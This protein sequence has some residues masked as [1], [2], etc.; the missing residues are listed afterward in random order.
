MNNFFQV[1]IEN[2]FVLLILHL[3]NI[4]LKRDSKIHILSIYVKL[5][6]LTKPIF[7]K[8]KKKKKKQLVEIPQKRETKVGKPVHINQVIPKTQTHN[9]I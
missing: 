1:F 3:T 9:T 5:K 6:K 7:G 2:N 4:L 8:K